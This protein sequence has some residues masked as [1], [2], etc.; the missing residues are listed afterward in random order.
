MN[1]TTINH[2]R[3]LNTG[4]EIASQPTVWKEVYQLIINQKPSLK[5][6]L[7]PI[8]ALKDLQIVLAGA[9]SSAF[10]GES[11]KTLVEQKTGKIT[12]A[13]PTTDIVTH[14]KLLS[15][16]NKPLL[17]VSF[18]R[19]G[20]SPESLETVELS[21]KYCREIYHLIITCNKD[22]KLAKYAGGNPE[23]CYSL[24]L[25]EKT[26]DK[27]LAMTSSFTSMLLSILLI[28][29]LEQLEDNKIQ[30]ESCIGS[31]K[32]IIQQKERLKIL[33]TKEYDRV[34]FL[35]SGELL[36]IARECSLKLQELT[37]GQLVC[38]HDSFLGFRHGPRAIVNEK[39]LMVY[40]FS[41]DSHVRKYENDLAYSIAQEPRGIC[42]LAVGTNCDTEENNSDRQSHIT[43]QAN[44]SNLFYPV[45]A[46]LIGQLLGYYRSLY[47]GLDPDNP[48]VSGAIS[49]VVQGVTIYNK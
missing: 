23:N 7:A 17:L 47:L 38:K 43:I 28:A 48:S 33:S 42:S 24:V 26:N 49:R 32:Q 39:T 14:P 12:Q 4:A 5:S 15:A 21:D 25:P 19:S 30:V 44:S 1:T 16:S 8:L 13:I 34:V 35:G 9:G 10:L 37:D 11:A 2:T 22:G 20:N 3:D 40:L 41:Q 18:G 36:G 46:T 27:S 29:D 45:A 31:A 6:F